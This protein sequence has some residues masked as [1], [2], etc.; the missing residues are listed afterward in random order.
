MAI[1]T[2]RQ[3]DCLQQAEHGDAE[4]DADA[5]GDQAFGFGMG[6]RRRGGFE[7]DDE[8]GDDGDAAERSQRKGGHAGA[9]DDFQQDVGDA[10]GD[11]GDEAGEEVGEAGCW[12]AREGYAHSASRCGRR[13]GGRRMG[14]AFLDVGGLAPPVISSWEFGGVGAGAQGTRNSSS[15]GTCKVLTRLLVSAAMPMMASRCMCW[16]SVMP[17][18]FA[19][20]VWEWMQYVQ[21]LAAETA[22]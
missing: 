11:G 13:L 21:P 14:W 12:W 22:M 18:C 17:F 2:G 3:R 16:A 7:P 5:E 10:E 19:A 6:S 4:Q 20:A 1:E 8:E 9:E 15:T